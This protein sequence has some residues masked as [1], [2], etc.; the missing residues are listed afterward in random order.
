MTGKNIVVTDHAILR[1]CER[2]YGVDFDPFRASILKTV[3]QAAKAGASSVYADGFTYVIQNGSV[4]TVLEGRQ[5][6]SQ[7]QRQLSRY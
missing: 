6:A 1:Y 2:L 3:E 4:I 5:S 7:K